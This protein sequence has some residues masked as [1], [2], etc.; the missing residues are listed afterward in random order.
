MNE[1]ANNE[2]DER[3]QKQIQQAREALKK[4]GIDFAVQVCGELLKK[5]PAAFEVRAVIWAALQKGTAQSSSRFG[6][7]KAR[8]S[9]MQFK[10]ANQ[11]LLKKDQLL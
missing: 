4:G 8:S 11:S 1:L 9:G 6:W 7:L 3:L 10:M 2:L 5:H